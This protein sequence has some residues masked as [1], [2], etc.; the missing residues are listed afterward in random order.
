[1][2]DRI[3]INGVWYIKESSPQ[4]KVDLEFIHFIGCSA[5]N[6]NHCFEATKLYKDNPNSELY[7]GFDIKY[8]D[9]KTKETELWDNDKWLI[10]VYNN[11]KKSLEELKNLSKEDI[12][13]LQAFLQ[14]LK[15]NNW[16]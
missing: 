16:F 4:I 6:K 8:T 12:Q 14:E 2:E 1:M 13:F 15:D 5:E 7:E 11:D 3:E 10:D 9:K